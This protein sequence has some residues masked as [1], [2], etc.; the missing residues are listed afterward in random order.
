[1]AKYDISNSMYG[2]LWDPTDG[3]YILQTV[4]NANLIRSNHRFAFEQFDIDPAITPRD[5]DGIAA[6]HSLQREL[7]ASHMMDMRA[8]LSETKPEDKT[9]LA[10]YTATIPDFSAPAFREQ[11]MEREY[12]NRMLAEYFGDDST[13]VDLYLD[14]VQEKVDS[15][16]Q[17]LSNMAAQLL[18]SGEIVYNHGRGIKGAVY[19]VPV[20]AENF[21]KAG[22]AVWTATTTKILSQMVE[23]QN[24]YLD[25]WG[26]EIPMKWQIPYDMFVNSFLKN[27][28]VI[29][30]IRY[31]RTVDGSPLPESTA[32][33][34]ELALRYLPAY[35]GLFPIEVVSE[36]QRDWTGTV[37][38]WKQNIAVL[39][40]QGS[41]GL[42]KHTTILEQEMYGKY[43][44]NAI[45]RVFAKT[46]QGLYT[47]MNTTLDNGNM[48]EWHT[49][50]FMA[51]VPALTEFLN[52]V[53]VDTSTADD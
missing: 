39:R 50:L 2:M 11:A 33:T 53:I 28:Q 44:A 3:P 27:E 45:S 21:S 30:W 38:G 31:M 19:K 43:G 5:N 25:K 16:D 41:A 26:E 32:L 36:K 23:I 22:E 37:S 52:H 12:K 51:A 8:P 15:A 29:E 49:D 35:P 48:R 14:K 40:P 24:R 13:I 6:F 42:I 10:S 7:N 47:V 34:Q 4:L 20:P 17:T 1:M 46:G 9:G 18:S